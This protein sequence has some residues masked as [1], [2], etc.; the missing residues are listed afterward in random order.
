MSLKVL[1]ESLSSVKRDT[2]EVGTVIR[3]VSAD[4]YTYAALKTPVGWYTT[5]SSAGEAHVKKILDFDGLVETLS[6]N[7][8]SKVEVATG[9]E[10]VLDENDLV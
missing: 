9:W 2:F 5:V 3:W 7:E 4:R 10:P 8:V 1:K 6:R